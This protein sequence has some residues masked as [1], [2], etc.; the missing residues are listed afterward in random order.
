EAE[1]PKV[2]KQVADAGL[3]LAVYS[4]GNDFFQ[5]DRE[6]WARQLAELKTGVDVAEQLETRT[7]RVFSGNAKPDYTLEQG[8]GWIIEGLAAGAEYA[9]RHGVTLALENHG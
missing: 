5:P 1:L 2:K 6:A 9:A 4:I 7:L 3:A 8:L